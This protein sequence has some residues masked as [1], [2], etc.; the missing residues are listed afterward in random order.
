[1]SFLPVFNPEPGFMNFSA[2][3]TS[4]CPHRPRA[5]ALG[6]ALAM[7][8]VSA[9]ASSP[10]QAPEARRVAQALKA[11]DAKRVAQA[12]GAAR[13]S[14]GAELVTRNS[15]VTRQGKTIVRVVQAYQGHRVWG[16]E[17]VV[18]AERNGT[19]R[20]AANG[21]AANVVPA[22]TPTLTQ[23]QAIAI[24][25]RTLGLKGRSAPPKAEL[26][27]FP[28]QY[29]GDVAMTW[30][31][32]TKRYVFDRANS[33]MS[34]R[35]AD[36]YV[37][38][39]EIELYANNRVDGVRDMKYVV[40]A[41]TGAV[42]H[43]QTGKQSLIPMN[44]PLQVDTDTAV[45]GTG[46]S[47]WSG[48]VP[49]DTTMHA[50]GTYQ[51][52]DRTRGSL[53]NPYLY[54]Y[55]TDEN[56]NPILAADGNPISVVGLQSLTETHEG[57]ADTWV[58][59]NWW[60]DGNPTNTWGDGRQFVM[61]PYGGETT[62]NGQTAAVDAHYG[63]ATTWDFYMNVF[64]R[65]GIDNR[66]TSPLSVVHVVDGYGYY[67]DN[68]YWS[69]FVFGMFYSDG[70][71]N[72]GVDPNTG[73]PTPATS[74]GFNSLTEID[75]I[76][77]E[78]THGVTANSDAL[79]YDGESGGLNESS[80][81]FMGSMVEAY[82]TRGAND[83]AWVIPNTGTDWLMGAQISASPLR[84]MIHPS[85]DGVSADNWYSGIQYLDVHFS[86]GPL[87]RMF[88]FLSQ[89]AS[90][91]PNSETY[92]PY[93]PGGMTGI[94]N[95]DAAHIWYAAMTE[96]LTPL[97]K[98]AEARNAAVNAALEYYGPGSAQVIAVRN[99]FAAIN[100]GTAT[101]EPRVLIQFPTVHARGSALNTYGGSLFAKMPIVSMNTTVHLEADVQHTTDKSVTWL[102][103][104]RPGAFNS[105][106]FRVAGGTATADGD[107]SPDNVW[108]YHS[109]T[110]VSNADPLEYAEG[111]VWVVNGDADGDTEFD[112]MDLGA[113]ALSWGLDGWVN[114]PNSIVGDGW[115][116]SM[117]VM[118]ID[119]AFRNAFGGV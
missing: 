113:V 15:M 41:R 4:R 81:D 3:P 102:P 64:G 16:T 105:P 108:G 39:Y 32:A 85:I 36:P 111:C 45:V 25:R 37:W 29:H 83:P 104:G 67:Y 101:D 93:L 18:H 61:Y 115:V 63:M 79:Q 103:G 5:A 57:F 96:W 68:A 2:L 94:G 107:W 109:M 23:D 76:G 24:A 110:V 75:I 10:I 48:T 116:D 91:D 95:D 49:L 114:A 72:A 46:Y 77:H 86:S 54:Y 33:V 71:L 20:I 100:V 17:A 27:V 70:T 59:S 73:M 89:G 42:M 62:T 31:E 1:M 117:D 7:L 38:A 65:N 8:S 11:P 26:I 88:Y 14:T 74:Y 78:M 80:S 19:S 21:L 55:F 22:G 51:M 40:D 97:A 44:P 87:N 13:E 12:L 53:M 43:V 69:D 92:S 30:N 90:S 34:V 58:A 35:P 106:G 47:Q 66:G 52:I 84:S 119:E 112:A 99:A 9:L 50:D 118:A 82:A 56:Y 60:Y 28:T 6:V 98:Y